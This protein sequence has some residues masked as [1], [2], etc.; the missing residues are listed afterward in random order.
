MKLATI[1]GLT[2]DRRS[3]RVLSGIVPADEAVALVKLAINKDRAPDPRFPVLVAVALTSTL[4][5]HRFKPTAQEIAAFQE[6][7]GDDGVVRNAT[8]DDLAAALEQCEA[9]LAAAEAAAK[10]AQDANVELQAGS[11]AL[12]IRLQAMEADNNAL[13]ADCSTMMDR[14]NSAAEKQAA[15]EDCISSLESKLVK[16]TELHEDL[17]KQRDAAREMTGIDYEAAA[18]KKKK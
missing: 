12:Q 15:A 4:R 18:S 3:G 8:A 13:R 9:R 1:I 7:A 6:E 14:L 10:A 5:E 16:L 17:L 2:P 11:N